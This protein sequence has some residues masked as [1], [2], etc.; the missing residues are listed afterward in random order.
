MLAGKKKP[1]I[2]VGERPNSA[3]S[4]GKE[5]STAHD[6]ADL[7][8]S[9]SAS[10]PTGVD[11]ERV[12]LLTTSPTNNDNA[13]ASSERKYEIDGAHPFLHIL[14]TEIQQGATQ[15]FDFVHGFVHE[16]RKNFALDRKAITTMILSFVASVFGF[17][18]VGLASLAGIF[19]VTSPLWFPLSF[20]TLP[21]WLPLLLFTSP[22]WISVG[23]TILACAVGASVF[24]LSVAFFFV[25]PEEWLPDK[26]SSEIVAWYLRQ[27]NIA[28]LWLA[29]MQ[30]KFLLY[31]AGVGPAADA[32][33]LVLEKI[34]VHALV[35]KLQK[36]D[37]DDLGS[38]IKHGQIGDIQQVLFEL[39]KSLIR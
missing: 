39:A 15:C 7:Q 11:D 19:L 36:V 22:V 10:S 23:A 29:K 13:Q 24:L 25:W 4:A 33:F 16:Q 20:I 9:S 21:L 38:K 27:R 30:T 31:A 28:T 34:D 12:F 14:P 26:E 2:D 32:A 35:S 8:T 3:Q 1:I 37:W 18:A 6:G 5:K 17:I